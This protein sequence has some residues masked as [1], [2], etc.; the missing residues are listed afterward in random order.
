MRD[1]QISAPAAVLDVLPEI[2]DGAV[3]F[4]DIRQLQ[5]ALPFQLGQG[6]FLPAQLVEGQ[7]PAEAHPAVGGQV[8]GHFIDLFQHFPPGLGGGVYLQPRFGVGQIAIAKGK[9]L[10]HALGRCLPA[11]P[12]QLIHRRQIQ[13]AGGGPQSQ[14]AVQ[15]PL[16]S[17][18]PPGPET[19]GRG[20]YFPFPAGKKG[21]AFPPSSP[22]RLTMSVKG[23]TIIFM[24]LFY[25]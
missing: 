1:G 14:R 4:P 23:G 24:F 12:D 22:F 6:V 9:A 5:T 7:R 20:R 10:G 11:S 3:A 2:P 25:R 8:R 19:H 18:R 17:H 13:P 16:S 15:R 21:A